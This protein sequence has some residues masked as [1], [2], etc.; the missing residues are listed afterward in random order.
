VPAGLVAGPAA[1]LTPL[2]D[3][4]AEQLVRGV[5]PGGTYL[6]DL[7]LRVS[8]LADDLPEITGL[9]SARSSPTQT[10]PSSWPRGSPWHPTT[11]TI[12]SC[13]S[14]ADAPVK[15][16]RQVRRTVCGMLPGAGRGQH[17]VRLPGHRRGGRGTVQRKYLGERV[18]IEP[19]DL[20]STHARSLELFPDRKDD[21]EGDQRDR[22]DHENKRRPDDPRS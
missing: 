15:A 12:R 5:V 11:R 19:E 14:Y 13:G 18:R 1:R 10:E 2:T 6:R 7:L 20:L 8:R 3:I 17:P 4:D 21:G 9:T 22:E 16:G